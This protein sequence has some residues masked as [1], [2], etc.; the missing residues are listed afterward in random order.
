MISLFYQI[1]ALVILCYLALLIGGTIYSYRKKYILKG[2]PRVS[3]I[4]STYN[5]SHRV[6]ECI[7]N[8]YSSYYKDKIDLV[9]VNDCSKDDT[10]EILKKLKKKYGFTLLNNEVNLGKTASLNKAFNFTK[11]DII[12]TIDS[13]IRVSRKAMYEMLA[14]LQDEKVALVSCQYTP[15]QDSLIARL[16]GVEFGF[17][18]VI[19]HSLS[20]IS[21]IMGLMGG[22]MAVKREPFIKVGLY[23]ASS[24]TE[25]AELTYKINELGYRSE[26]CKEVVKCQVHES[27][28]PIYKQRLRWAAGNLVEAIRHFK[29]FILHPINFVFVILYL[30][31]SFLGA[32]ITIINYQKIYEVGKFILENSSQMGFITSIVQANAQNEFILSW[33]A[34]FILVYPIVFIPPLITNDSKLRKNK[35]RIFIIYLYSIIYVPLLSITIVLGVIKGIYRILNLNKN[36]RGW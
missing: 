29:T 7:D 15:K 21:S 26:I 11:E 28:K 25:D 5:E 2:K 20:I 23:D 9:V 13:D 35:A 22:C 19:S 4:L 36:K 34:L 1:N 12:I 3:V 17:I 33:L 18:S 10:L 14:R 8:L 31:M 24:L 32:L 27:V 6:K 30:S 16:Q